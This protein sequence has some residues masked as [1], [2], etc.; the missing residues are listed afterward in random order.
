M[1]RK[2]LFNDL[3]RIFDIRL[4]ASHRLNM[5]SV[6][7]WQ[8]EKPTIDDFKRDIIDESCFVYEKNNVVY[9][10]VTLLATY[11]TSYSGVVSPD[12]ES[13]TIHRMAVSNDATH[14]GIGHALMTFAQSYALSLQKEVLFVDT[15]PKNIFMQKLIA[16]HQFEFVASIILQDIPSPKR[17][18]YRKSLTKC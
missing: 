5:Q 12:V 6:N 16:S 11:D 3:N 18:L 1:I 14:E 10:M 13:V 7:Q 2:A 4:E 9:G 8:S 17:Y 15:H